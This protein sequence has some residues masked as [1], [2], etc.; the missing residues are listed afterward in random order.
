MHRFVELGKLGWALNRT[1]NRSGA[2]AAFREQIAIYG[3]NA[4]PHASLALLAAAHGDKDAAL[5]HFHDAVMR[6]FSDV[7]RFERSEVWQPLA[8]NKKFLRLAD[9]VPKLIEKETSWPRWETLYT[10]DVVSDLG[11]ASG[12]STRW[13]TAGPCRSMWPISC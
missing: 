1:G 9:L 12:S 10:V 7:W 5:T 6:G 2:E 3:F 8:K 11:R 13:S 4:E